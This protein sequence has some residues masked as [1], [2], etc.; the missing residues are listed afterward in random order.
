MLFSVSLKVCGTCDVAS[1]RSGMCTGEFGKGNGHRAPRQ[2]LEDDCAT[3]SSSGSLSKVG[4]LDSC[5]S[6]PSSSYEHVGEHANT[7]SNEQR[8]ASVPQ[9]RAS[10]ARKKSAPTRPLPT[11][12]S[13]CR[14]QAG[15]ARE[16][17]QRAEQRQVE[18]RLPE[19]GSC[20]LQLKVL[21]L[22]D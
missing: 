15:S 10:H 13:T 18:P 16:Q 22:T 8:C 9:E 21:Y 17:Q 2:S 4:T 5:P 7:S 3:P 20:P 12:T 1:L 14:V 11:N 6:P 19:I